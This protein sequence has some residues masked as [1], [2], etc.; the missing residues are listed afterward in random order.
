MEGTIRTA[1]PE[2]SGAIAAIYAPFVR[3]S[4]VSFETEPPT[5]AEI[6]ARIRTTLTYA[7]WLVHEA[8]G[9]VDGYAYGS[10]FRDRPAYSWSAEA[11]VYVRE[12]RRGRG[13]GRALLAALLEALAERGFRNA[14]AII[15]LPN[16]PSIALFESLGFAPAG[17]WR[18]A[19]WKLGAWWDVGVWQKT[20]REGLVPS[21]PARPPG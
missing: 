11:S 19:G 4:H 5:A 3:D 12:D 14:F 2:D 18:A 21:E 7:P 15:A 10:R 9:E 16:E 20:L 1:R 6:A 17:T 8:G 13:I